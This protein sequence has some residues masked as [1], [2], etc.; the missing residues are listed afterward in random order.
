MTSD[1]AT[2][3]NTMTPWEQL[4]AEALECTRCP[5][6][7]ERQQVVFGEGPV[8]CDFLFIGQGPSESDDATGRNYNGPSGEV[9]DKALTQ[10]GLSRA[11]IY[12]T[13][14]T[15]CAAFEG[16][17]KPRKLRPPKAAEVR[18]CRPWL[19]QQLALI[20]PR[21][22]VC[23]GAVAAREVIDRK[24]KLAEQ[25]GQ[26]FDGPHNTRIIATWQPAYLMRLSQHDRPRAVE[27][28]RQLVDDLRQAANAIA[29]T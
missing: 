3:E 1:T 25:R 28:W 5:L 6:A 26:W 14:I 29:A 8:P 17:G 24:F 13:N 27:G 23:S 15:L 20:K 12:V 21:I 7:Q 9:L 11:N 16:S 2:T 22:I 10:A 4:R 19:D 18:T